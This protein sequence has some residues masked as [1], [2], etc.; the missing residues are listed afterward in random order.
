MMKLP[1]RDTQTFRW[2]SEWLGYPRI[3]EKFDK[4][5]ESHSSGSP[6][7]Q[8]TED[9]F[10]WDGVYHRQKGIA[11]RFVAGG[12]RRRSRLLRWKSGHAGGAYLPYSETYVTMEVQPAVM[13]PAGHGIILTA[14]RAAYI[15]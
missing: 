13:S 14:S 15:P 11:N 10:D 2:C 12:R 5:V 4:S 3:Q 6:D 1:G 8:N 7:R 9:G